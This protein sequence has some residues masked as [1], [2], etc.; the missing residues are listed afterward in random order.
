MINGIILNN[1]MMANIELNKL[2]E[3]INSFISFQ[4]LYS[5]RNQF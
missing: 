3:F 5:V 2:N 4:I 1:I